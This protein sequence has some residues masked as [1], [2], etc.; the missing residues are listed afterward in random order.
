M[1]IINPA[2]ASV[3]SAASTVKGEIHISMLALAVAI[4]I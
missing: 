4:A 1:P 3:G 2:P